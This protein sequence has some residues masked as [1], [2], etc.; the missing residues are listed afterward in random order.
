M[1]PPTQVRAL[2]KI[3][4]SSSAK[5]KLCAPEKSLPPRRTIV[6]T[7]LPGSTVGRRHPSGAPPGSRRAYSRPRPRIRRAS[8]MSLTMMVTRFPWIAQR[9]ASSKSW[10]KWASVASWSAEIADACLR[11]RARSTSRRA[12][13]ARAVDGW[14]P[15]DA[16]PELGVAGD[17]VADLAHEPRERQLADEQLRAPLVDADLLERL[18]SRALPVLPA[19]RRRGRRARAR[20]RAN[21]GCL[22]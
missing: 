15:R 14:T 20:G 12:A 11:G 6:H 9:L 3:E 21:A 2:L 8:W 13:G 7:T 16:P 19:R 17:V 5:L 22:F 10:T 18:L 1:S 4:C